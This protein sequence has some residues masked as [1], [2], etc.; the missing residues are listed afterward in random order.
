M[1]QFFNVF[2]AIHYPILLEGETGTGKSTL[3]KKYAES[4]GKTCTR[5]NITGQTLRE[6]LIGRA[7]LIDGNVQWQQGILIHALEQQKKTERRLLDM[8]KKL[9][10]ELA[11]LA[12]L[13]PSL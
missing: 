10:K 1:S 12:L 4:K 13:T 5:I 2:D 7:T 8:Q 3:V 6:D 9:E 11:Q